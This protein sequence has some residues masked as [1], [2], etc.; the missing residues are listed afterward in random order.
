MP[1]MA[2]TESYCGKCGYDLSGLP[3]RGSCP[4]CGQRYDTQARVGIQRTSRR[5]QKADRLLRRIRTIA[6]FLAAGVVMGCAG[7]LS[8]K[9]VTPGKPLVAGAFLAVLCIVA[10]ITSFLYERED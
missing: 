8:L 2:D 9:A 10:G 3:V 7:L 5:Q 4:E 1:T 6:C